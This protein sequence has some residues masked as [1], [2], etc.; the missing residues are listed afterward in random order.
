MPI[1]RWVTIMTSVYV[2]VLSNRLVFLK[3][4]SIL[5]TNNDTRSEI[6]NIIKAKAIHQQLLVD[7]QYVFIV[8]TARGR[9]KTTNILT[10]LE[11]TVMK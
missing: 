10:A 3:N 11:Q 6:N 7:L 1:A 9:L 8:R 5:K 4:K 2:H